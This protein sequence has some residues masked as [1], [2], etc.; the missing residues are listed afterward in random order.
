VN[1]N[2]F[3]NPGAMFGP[4][5]YYNDNFSAE[6]RYNLS[7][8]TQH[9]ITISGYGD[10]SNIAPQPFISENIILL[11]DGLCGSTCSVFAE[12]M[13]TIGGVRSSKL[14]YAP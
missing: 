12:L 8:P 4:Y 1:G 14:H 6:L 5:Q 3:P 11:M 9:T 2:D 10:R 13:K 7:D